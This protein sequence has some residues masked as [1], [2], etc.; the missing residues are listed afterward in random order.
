MDYTKIN[1]N[2][3]LDK[4]ILTRKYRQKGLTFREIAKMLDSDV[5][6]VFRWSR[7]RLPGDVDK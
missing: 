2:T 4:V 1:G 3:R 7:Y 6:T 5:K